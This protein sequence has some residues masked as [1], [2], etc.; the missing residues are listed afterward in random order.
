ML[1][2]NLYD[3]Q[4]KWGMSTRYHWL[5]E[6][7]LHLCTTIEGSILSRIFTTANRNDTSIIIINETNLVGENA[8]NEKIRIQTKT[9]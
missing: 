8:I 1:R 5:K 9:S 2:S 3:S 7:Q 4:A 6:Y